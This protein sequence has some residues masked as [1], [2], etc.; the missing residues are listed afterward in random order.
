MRSRFS[1]SALRLFELWLRPWRRHRIA[2]IR[3]AG[4]PRRL[5]DD[6]PLILAANHVGW[7]DAFTLREV[8]RILRPNAPVWTL[9]SR[10]ELGRYPYFRLIGVFGIDVGSPASVLGAVR[11]LAARL[12]ERPDSAAIFFPQGRIWPSHRRPLGFRRGIEVFARRLPPC[13]V[14]P[15]AIHHEPLSE[16][17]PTIFV[18]AGEPVRMDGEIDHHALEAAV[19]AE[20]DRLLDFL[21]RHGEDA[22]RRWPGAFDRL[23]SPVSA[24][25]VWR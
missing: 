3:I 24:G 4:L 18:S 7:W 25:H 11:W 19:E 1:P 10:G 21:A 2:A 23:E 8:H 13:I 14:L 17:A 9:M 16:P 6:V 22:G 20:A 5:P 15:I 12:R